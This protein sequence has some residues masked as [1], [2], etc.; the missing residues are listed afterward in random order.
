MIDFTLYPNL[1]GQLGQNKVQIPDGINTFWP[2]GDALVENFV[3]KDSKLV[4]IV[5]TKALINNEASST[6]FPYDFVEITLDDEL[7]NTLTINKGER[8]K[9]LNIKFSS[10]IDQLILPDGYKRLEYLES[11]GAQHIHTNIFATNETGASAKFLR[12]KPFSNIDAQ[13][14]SLLICRSQ[15]GGSGKDNFW[16]IPTIYYSGDKIFAGFGPRYAI[17]NTDIQLHKIYTSSINFL[18]NSKINWNNEIIIDIDRNLYIP[19]NYCKNSLVLGSFANDTLNFY[20]RYNWVGNIYYCSISQG[21][22]LVRNYIPCLNETGT[23]CMFDTVTQTPFYNNGTGDFLYPGSE[24]QVV[25]SS[26][27][28]KFYAKM[29]EHGIQR[30]YKTPDNYSGTKDDYASE[31]GFKE[32][33][34]PPMPTDGHWSPQWIETDTQLIC[35]W[36]EAEEMEIL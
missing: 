30:L 13:S 17:E 4:G 8:T 11:T 27:D 23:P 9:Y 36:V 29:T 24:S 28:D 35:N 19:D 22:K 26:I 10:E 31:Y 34:E 7:E 14:S 5:D 15:S 2:D 12:K 3:Y 16:E 21:T 6:T 32:I 18:N 1:N 25:T 33:V 20:Q